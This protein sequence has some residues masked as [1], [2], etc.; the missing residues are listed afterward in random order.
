MERGAGRAHR[1]AA[2][3]SQGGG[4]RAQRA[5][6][7]GAPDVAPVDHPG[8]HEPVVERRRR[9]E[10]PRAAGHQVDG[11]RVDLGRAERLERGP[12]VAEVGGHAHR[13]AIRAR[14]E[15]AV[16]LGH[17]LQL[18]GVEVRD[19]GR[20]VQLD[21]PGPSGP[22]EREQLLIERDQ[23]VEAFPGLARAGRR[24]GQR[25]EG[26]RADDDGP[27]R[28]AL[29]DR[30]RQVRENGFRVEREAGLVGD[31][32]DQ[33]VVVG[34]EPLGHLERPDLRGAA[35]RGEVAVE[36]V[37]DT[38]DPGREGAQQDGGVEHLVV[39]GERVGGDGVEPGPGHP[40]AVVAAQ[41]GRDVAQRPPVECSGPVGLHGLLEFPVRPDAGR[42]EGGGG[43]RARAARGPGVGE[44]H[45]G[46]PPVRLISAHRPSRTRRPSMAPAS[47]ARPGRE[48]A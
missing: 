1:E 24:L 34:V 45:F 41:P 14:G 43:E 8:Q 32:G 44:C 13:R 29:L 35:G 6:E 10:R 36:R 30:L 5:V 33:V 23:V 11:D 39:V 20:L 28:D 37:L 15:R 48:G 18:R 4:Q 27:R 12:R 25:E 9:R 19:E 31:L 7:V 2:R 21:P 22:Q 17:L 40:G 46:R 3:R 38:L 42:A 47:R 16:D 26:G